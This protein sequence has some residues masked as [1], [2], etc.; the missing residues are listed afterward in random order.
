[1][2]KVKSQL[3]KWL[4]KIKVQPIFFA[5][6]PL[7]KGIYWLNFTIFKN[8]SEFSKGLTRPP[9]CSAKSLN[10]IDIFY[11]DGTPYEQKYKKNLGRLL[12]RFAN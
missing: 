2:D 5:L 8:I 1:M 4:K 11:F 3:S 12:F 7:P 6:T 9:A 10:F